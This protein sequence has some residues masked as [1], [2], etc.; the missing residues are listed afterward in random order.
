M[1]YGG[2]GG[3]KAV[4]RFNRDANVAAGRSPYGGGRR[5][6]KPEPLGPIGGMLLISTE[7]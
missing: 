4:K 6:P 1:K 7:N 3:W 5:Y 2:Q